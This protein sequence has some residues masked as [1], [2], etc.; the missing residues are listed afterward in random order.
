MKECGQCHELN[1]AAALFCKRCGSNDW[2]GANCPECG[3]LNPS[4]ADYCTKCGVSMSGQSQ[5]RPR[6]VS[7]SAQHLGDVAAMAE[8][9]SGNTAGYLAVSMVNRPKQT[10]IGIFIGLLLMGGFLLALSM[11]DPPPDPAAAASV[12]TLPMPEG[13]R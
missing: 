1:V 3:T 12:T 9:A 10:A 13:S 6:G 8:L 4:N 7:R 5:D 11:P 2:G